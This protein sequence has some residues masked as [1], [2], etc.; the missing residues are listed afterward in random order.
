MSESTKGGSHAACCVG[1][2]H[3]S[4][5][6]KMHL[7]ELITEFQVRVQGSVGHSRHVSFV[8]ATYPLNPVLISHQLLEFGEIKRTQ[9]V[10][11]LEM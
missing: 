6:Y 9:K 7:K 11:N 10:P 1:K 5:K 2:R 8:P 4:V 3:I